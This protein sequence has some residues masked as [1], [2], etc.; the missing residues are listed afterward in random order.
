MFR[1]HDEEALQKPASLRSDRRAYV[2]GV[3]QQ[4]EELER[5]LRDDQREFHPEEDVGQQ[6]VS[7]SLFLASV[8]CLLSPPLVGLP[9]RLR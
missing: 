4:T 1:R 8:W 6:S 9:D 3:R 7:L 5:I 2:L